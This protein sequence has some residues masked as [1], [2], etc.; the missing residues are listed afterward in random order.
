MTLTATEYELLRILSANAGRAVASESLLS[1]LRGTRASED[2]ER[3]RAFV[4]Q[5]RTKLVD[6]AA[7]AAFLF[8]ECGV[9]Y[10]HAYVCLL[11]ADGR[12]GSLR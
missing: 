1:Q 11:V 5:L 12:A 8:A 9:G 6:D 2:T 7:S 3:V 4:T 10:R